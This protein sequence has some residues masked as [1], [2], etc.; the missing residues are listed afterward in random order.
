MILEW[1][2]SDESRGTNLRSWLQYGPL[3]ARMDIYALGCIPYELLAGAG[4]FT[5][6]TLDSFRRQHLAAPIPPIAGGTRQLRGSRRPRD[7]LA[8]SY[9]QHGKDVPGRVLEPG[10]VWALLVG[11]AARNTAFIRQVVIL[12]ERNTFASQCSDRVLNIVDGKI[13]NGVGCGRVVGF[14]VDEN[15]A[16]CR[17]MEGQHPMFFGNL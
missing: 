13:E 17:Q 8:L 6:T 12:L 1:I 10:D 3:N 7:D 16:A 14:W 9:F 15:L 4:P 5:A 11:N 2:A